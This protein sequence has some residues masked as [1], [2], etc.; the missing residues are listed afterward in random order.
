MRRVNHSREILPNTEKK[1]TG[2]ID[3][4][5]EKGYMQGERERLLSGDSRESLNKAEEKTQISA[6]GGNNNYYDHR[7]PTTYHSIE[8][9]RQSG[10]WGENIINIY[11]NQSTSE[12]KINNT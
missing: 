9:N 8:T 3:M 6:Q 11:T 12:K 7:Q 10:V 4:E 1:G 5:R 2:T